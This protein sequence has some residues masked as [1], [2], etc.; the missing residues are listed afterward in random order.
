[1]EPKIGDFGLAKHARG[2]ET[3]GKYTHVT[4]ESDNGKVYGSLPYLPPE[5]FKNYQFSTKL[6]T[7]CFGVVGFTFIF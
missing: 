6:D 2:G 7:Y 5:F 3:A 1:M 4:V